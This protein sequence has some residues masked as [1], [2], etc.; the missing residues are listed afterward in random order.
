MARDLDRRLRGLGRA[1]TAHELDEA[2]LAGA[3]EEFA[4]AVEQAAQGDA[5]GAVDYLIG[6]RSQWGSRAVYTAAILYGAR[7]ANEVGR[8]SGKR[9][10]KVARRL[11]EGLALAVHI[12]ARGEG[13]PP[14]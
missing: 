2:R 9:S 11:G 7:A 4:R 1:P 13:D 6:A 14:A 3:I 5:S 12:E 10:D 8:L